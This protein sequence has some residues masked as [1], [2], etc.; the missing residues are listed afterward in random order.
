MLS[1][2]LLKSWLA[3]SC[4]VLLTACEEPGAQLDAGEGPPVDLG[5]D[6]GVSQDAGSEDLG[7]DAGLQDMGLADMGAPELEEPYYL[8]LG[9]EVPGE[10]PN[11]PPLVFTTTSMPASI[12]GFF[13]L[14]AEDAQTGYQ[15]L[16]GLNFLLLDGLLMTEPEAEMRG[17]TIEPMIASTVDVEP[18][19]WVIDPD[20]Q[21]I[22]YSTSQT[23]DVLTLTFDPNDP[24]NTV[25]FGPPLSIVLQEFDRPAGALYGQWEA[26]VVEYADGAQLTPTGCAQAPDGVYASLQ[27]RIEV[28]PENGAM[29]FDT[30]RRTY[31]DPACTMNEQLEVVSGMGYTEEFAS[32]IDTWLLIEGQGARVYNRWNLTSSP[33]GVTLD[34]SACLPAPECE[35]NPLL[36]TRIELVSR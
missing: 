17:F 21:T 9:I 27:Y 30:E 3:V 16:F 2:C 5:A 32:A 13:S 12:R 7:I 33:S 1:K 36:P 6:L 29:R 35:M 23:G 19:A 26:S 24:R 14:E 20:D 11:D 8:L 4:T 28:L 18:G 34:W 31:S 22:V 15:R 10:S 25:P